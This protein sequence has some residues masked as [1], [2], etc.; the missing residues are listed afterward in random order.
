MEESQPSLQSLGGPRSSSNL[1]VLWASFCSWALASGSEL[2]PHADTVLETFCCYPVCIW[3]PAC[4]R[5]CQ[6]SG[7]A[8]GGGS[9][10]YSSTQNLMGAS[11]PL[12][13]LRF[14]R[15]GEKKSSI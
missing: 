8:W 14:S 4:H 10:P 7:E 13:P 2:G 1:R 15:G 9:G 6:F 3:Q 11:L 12:A 5:Q